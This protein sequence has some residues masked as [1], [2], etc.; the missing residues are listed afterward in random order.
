MAYLSFYLTPE[1]FKV[2]QEE[3][4]RQIRSSEELYE[5]SCNNIEQS[6]R[7]DRL[8]FTVLSL[9]PL[10]LMMGFAGYVGYDKLNWVSSFCVLILF[11]TIAYAWYLSV[12]TDSHYKYV[13][14]KFG[15]VQKRNRAEPKWLNRGLQGTAF[16]CALGSLFAVIIA[17]PMALTGT[18]VLLLFALGLMKR[19][20][21]NTFKTTIAQQD[22]W[23]FA[24][25][26]RQRKVIRLFHKYDDC[27]YEDVAATIARRAQGRCGTYLFFKSTNE[28]EEIVKLLSKSWNLDCIEIDNPK[29]LFSIQGS[30]PE[31]LRCIPARS[32]SYAVADTY[33]LKKKNAELPY[34]KYFHG[35]KWL[36]KAELKDASRPTSVME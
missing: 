11:I 6:D 30:N 5:W 15:L 3:Q 2:Y 17:G 1:E 35:G 8:K 12:G 20:P 4:E 27:Y 19:K 22:D 26:N 7:F 36:T 25:Y 9:V 18:G 21:Q 29:S 28:L 14:S 24:H 23:L 10:A 31:R 13:L 34:W 33:E 32:Q 16:V